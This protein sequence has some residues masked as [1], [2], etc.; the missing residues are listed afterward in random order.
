MN[1][2]REYLQEYAQDKEFEI[3]VAAWIAYHEAADRIDGDISRP[4]T[5]EEHSRCAEAATAGHLAQ[6]EFLKSVGLGYL[7]TNREFRDKWNRANF[8]ALRRLGK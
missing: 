2:K 6:K 7:P 8:E 5:M 3:L 1:F 4:R